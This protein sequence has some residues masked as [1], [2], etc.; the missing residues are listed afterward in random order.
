[1]TVSNSIAQG[2]RIASLNHYERNIKLHDTGKFSFKKKYIWG[3][4]DVTLIKNV[5]GKV[6]P[7][8]AMKAYRGSRTTAAHILT[9]TL[10]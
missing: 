4:D 6:A 5:K 9:E 8:H 1:M 2:L 7:V 3:N 10:D